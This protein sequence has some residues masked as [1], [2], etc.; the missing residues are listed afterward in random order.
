MFIYILF[1]KIIITFPS[2][3]PDLSDEVSLPEIYDDIKYNVDKSIIKSY[4]EKYERGKVNFKTGLNHL[5]DL[6]IMKLFN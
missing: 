6:K 3:L 5:A 1:I 4:N 2:C